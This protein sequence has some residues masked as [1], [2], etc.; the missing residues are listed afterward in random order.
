MLDLDATGLG[1]ATEEVVMAAAVEE[2]KEA[3][4]TLRASGRLPGQ[5][6]AG[7][8]PLVNPG[9]SRKNKDPGLPAAAAGSAAT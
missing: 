9:V 4:E 3:A 1:S 6:Q 2:M 8:C 5:N 7:D